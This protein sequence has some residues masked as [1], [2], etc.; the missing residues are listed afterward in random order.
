MHTSAV[1]TAPNILLIPC[2]MLWPLLRT[3]RRRR[4][5]RITKTRRI[6]SQRNEPFALLLNHLP[7]VDLIQAKRMIPVIDTN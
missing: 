7:L 4:K 3:V 6:R 2:L 1:N 5:T